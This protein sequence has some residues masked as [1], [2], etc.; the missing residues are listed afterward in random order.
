MKSVF[1]PHLGHNVKLARRAPIAPGLHLKLAHFVKL[2]LVATPDECDYSAKSA[3][4][5]KN[6]YLNDELGDC[7]IAAGYHLIGLLTGLATGTPYL[8]SKA[9]LLHDYS[10]IGGYV[11]GDPSTDNGCDEE[12]ALNFW[13]RKGFAD[14]SKLLGWLAV[15]PKSVA[16]V[17]AAFFLFENLLFGVGLP[18]KWIEPFPEK[19]GF[20]WDF[21][22][23]ANPNNGHAFMAVAYTKDGVIIDT[24]G[25]RGLITW[26]AIAQYCI[27]GGALYVGLSPDML[28]KGADKAPNGLAWAS[29]IA[30]FDAMGGNVPVPPAPPPLPPAPGPGPTPPAAAVSMSQAQAWAKQGLESSGSFFLTRSQAERYAMHGIAANW[31][32]GAS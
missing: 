6:V 17:K 20:V 11:P 19:D 16:E 5:L 3:A 27:H 29:I 1:A 25:L 31:P 23:P 4:V 8:A 21:A 24:W 28:A 22:G 15:N 2:H 30:Q 13:M 32:K 18:D 14:G 12:T 7:V 9:S 26:E 10:A